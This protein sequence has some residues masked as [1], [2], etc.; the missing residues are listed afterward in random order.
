MMKGNIQHPTSNIQR[1]TP[2]RLGLTGCLILDVGCSVLPLAIVFLG[3]AFALHGQT[4]ALPLLLPPYEEI[5]PN[6][7][8]QLQIVTA[9]HPVSFGLAGLG[10]IIVLAFGGWMVLRPRPKVMIPPAVQA[11]QALEILRHQ[12]EDGTA[13]SHVSQIVRNYFIA[14]F[15]LPPGEFTTAEFSRALSDHEQIGAELSTAATNFLRDCDA[16]KFSATANPAPADAA[17]RALQLVAQAEQWRAQ[18]RQS[19]ETQTQGRRV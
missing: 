18:I 10:I 5:P 15:Q 12:P 6:L 4:N 1:P 17:S 3:S 13:L 2:I 19:A 11:R 9:Q 14:A 16:K 8:E 7:S